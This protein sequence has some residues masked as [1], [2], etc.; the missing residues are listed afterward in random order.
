MCML[1]KN[2]SEAIWPFEKPSAASVVF[3]CLSARAHGSV[4]AEVGV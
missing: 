2:M 4:Q 1:H 3:L